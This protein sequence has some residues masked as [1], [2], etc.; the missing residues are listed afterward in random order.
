MVL[1]FPGG[2]HGGIHLAARGDAGA[3][4]IHLSGIHLSSAVGFS[5]D[6]SGIG[7]F[8]ACIEMLG[9]VVKE[10][11]EYIILGV[12]GISTRTCFDIARLLV[13]GGISTWQITIAE[14]FGV[15]FSF[16]LFSLNFDILLT[17]L[18]IWEGLFLRILILSG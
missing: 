15:D 4:G 14:R 17:S 13:T 12:G 5:F 2:A 1:E 7:G 11:F 3:R 10:R 8:I 6:P 18:N 16:D 9:S